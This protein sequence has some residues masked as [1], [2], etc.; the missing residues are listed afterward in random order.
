MNIHRI[1]HVDEARQWITDG[2]VIAYPTE[3]VYGLGCDPFNQSAVEKILTLKQRK[4]S[5][6]LILLIS[7]WTQL[8]PLVSPVSEHLLEM[9]RNTWPGPVTWVFPKSPLIPPWLSGDWSTIA[10]RMSAHP[11]AQALCSERPIV[12][13]S[14]NISGHAPAMNIEHLRTQFPK[15]VDAVLDG[16]LGDAAQPSAIYDVLSGRRLR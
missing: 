14:A 3:A 6:G 2:K 5:K 11:L 16:P 15:G 8:A 9:V 4:A 12:S 7:H 10:V 1:S 13:T